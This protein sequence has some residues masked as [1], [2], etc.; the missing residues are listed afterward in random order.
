M[1][2]ST[3]KLPEELVEMIWNMAHKIERM[4][5][6]AASVIQNVY[7]NALFNP[8]CKLGLNKINREMAFEDGEDE[9]LYI[10]LNATITMI[11]RHPGDV[12]VAR[13]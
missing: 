13:Q 9:Y 1:D 3:G 12:Q 2:F 8:N 11:T 4:R 7:K 10:A 6:L 5:H